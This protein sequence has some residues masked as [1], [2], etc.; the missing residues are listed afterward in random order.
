MRWPC[1]LGV[2]GPRVAG[3][4][5]VAA[6]GEVAEEGSVGAGDLVEAGE[7]AVGLP[8]V[9]EEGVDEVVGEGLR[10]AVRAVVDQLVK[11]AEA[12]V[13]VVGDR[14]GRRGFEIEEAV[15]VRR[16]AGFGRGG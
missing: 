5:V 3:G 6:S 1:P 4:D 12:V 16:A 7:L 14:P 9:V 15:L 2:V 11:P 13:D 8:G 10:G